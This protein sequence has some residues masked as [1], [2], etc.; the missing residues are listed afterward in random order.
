MNQEENKGL[1]KVQKRWTHIK[2]DFA[3]RGIHGV[4]FHRG[5]IDGRHIQHNAT[6]SFTSTI[7][8]EN[9]NC[10]TLQEQARRQKINH[11][12]TIFNEWYRFRGVTKSQWRH[13]T[14]KNLL[15]FWNEIG[16]LMLSPQCCILNVTSI[17][18]VYLSIDWKWGFEWQIVGQFYRLSTV[19]PGKTKRTSVSLHNLQIFNLIIYNHC[20][21]QRAARV[22]RGSI[23]GRRLYS[24]K[25][26][27][28]FLCCC[29]AL[30]TDHDVHGAHAD[31]CHWIQ[32]YNHNGM[33]T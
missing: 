23:T 21:T 8:Q 30:R 11:H 24:W 1:Q 26:N 25:F 33:V 29:K 27:M 12:S 4:V 13:I 28:Q 3:T 31:L 6:L 18:A 16:L 9:W 2:P 14:W 32:P 22:H 15:E 20:W 10:L 5:P 17:L 19:T 7:L